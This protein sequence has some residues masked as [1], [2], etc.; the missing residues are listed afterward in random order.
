MDNAEIKLLNNLKHKYCGKTIFNNLRYEFY[1]TNSI[2]QS[3]I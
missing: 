1:G 3:K 2:Q